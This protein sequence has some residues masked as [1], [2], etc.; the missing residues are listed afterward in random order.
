MNYQWIVKSGKWLWKLAQPRTHC[1]IASIMKPCR[2]RPDS[3]GITF[4]ALER[5]IITNRSSQTRCIAPQKSTMK[6]NLWGVKV[7][8]PTCN[9]ICQVTWGLSHLTLSFENARMVNLTLTL[10]YPLRYTQGSRKRQPSR[11]QGVSKMWL[12]KALFF[13]N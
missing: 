3:K 9:W 5:R 13:T 1:S 12:T 10:C 8:H 7:H 11:G 4:S 6:R 2:K